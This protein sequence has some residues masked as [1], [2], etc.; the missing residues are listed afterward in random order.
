MVQG[1]INVGGNEDGFVRH[2]A[3]LPSGGGVVT[4]PCEREKFY[5]CT[6]L[7]RVVKFVV[8]IDNEIKR[9]LVFQSRA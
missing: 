3:A 7:P 8:S 2:V 5:G 9:K 1:Q 4:V 6:D